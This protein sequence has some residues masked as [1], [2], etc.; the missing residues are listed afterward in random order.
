MENFISEQYLQ[1]FFGFGG[2]C[3]N[4]RCASKNYWR[5]HD[6]YNGGMQKHCCYGQDCAFL[7]TLLRQEKD[8]KQI[9]EITN[10]MSFLAQKEIYE[11]GNFM[12]NS[13]GN[14][15]C[16]KYM[17]EAIKK[18]IKKYTKMKEIKNNSLFNNY[19]KEIP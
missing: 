18:S 11:Y 17:L 6:F 14:E 2:K 1:E 4:E 8:K 10:C 7:I 3:N 19:I 9:E 16:K 13:C 15:I 5:I 12:K